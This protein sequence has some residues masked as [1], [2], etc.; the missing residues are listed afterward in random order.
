MTCLLKWLTYRKMLRQQ[1]NIIVSQ[2]QVLCS[3]NGTGRGVKQHGW[4][5]VKP[6]QICK[7]RS[8][9]SPALGDCYT[10]LPARDLGGTGGVF[11]SFSCFNGG[12]CCCCLKLI[13][14][15]VYC[16]LFFHCSLLVCRGEEMA[17]FGKFVHLICNSKAI[18]LIMSVFGGLAL[19]VFGLHECT[20]SR[21]YPFFLPVAC[22]RKRVRD[23]NIRVSE[24]LILALSCW[25]VVR[26]LWESYRAMA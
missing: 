21:G 10:Q 7:Q 24:G 12:G 22:S 5:S 15:F 2:A 23:W 11:F 19:I 14:S 9:P 20:G 25:A 4:I 13:Y 8:P 26:Q 17:I 3:L 6:S 16:P 18:V 1:C